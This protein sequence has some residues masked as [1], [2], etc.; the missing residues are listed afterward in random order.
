MLHFVLK[1]EADDEKLL[2][3]ENF[4]VDFYVI[5]KLFVSLN[6]DLLHKI[7]CLTGQKSKENMLFATGGSS[8]RMYFLA[9]KILGNI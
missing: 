8:T 4:E 2:K 6:I 7:S 3:D 5:Y 9:V 1:D